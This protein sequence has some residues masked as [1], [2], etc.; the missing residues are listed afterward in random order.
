[1]NKEIHARFMGGDFF[2]GIQDVTR[3]VDLRA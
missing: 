2:M 1:M 3:Q